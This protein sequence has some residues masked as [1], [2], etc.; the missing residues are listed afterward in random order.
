MILT[1][2]EG[3]IA[4]VNEQAEIL[5]GYGR[6]ELV[7]QKID[8]LLPERLRD[9]H[10]ADR[11]NYVAHP[12]MRLMGASRDVFA[13]RKDGAE[14]PV[15]IGLSPIVTTAGNMVLSA[16]ADITAR[17][18][19]EESQQLVIREL[20]HRTQNLLTVVQTVANRS[21]DEAKTIADAKLV[22]NGRL[23]AL[24]HAYAMLADA[25]WEG[26]PL[27]KIIERQ[28]R[29]MS[30]RI[31]VSGCDLIVVPSAA[32]QFAMIIHELTTNALKYGSLSTPQ[33][34]VSIEGNIDRNGTN[35]TLSFVWREIGGPTIAPPTR[36]G[37]GSVI[38]LDSAKSFAEDV[39]VE[40]AP[41]GLVYGLKLRLRDIEANRRA[42]AF[43]AT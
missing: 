13:R 7:G 41:T 8:M 18:K 21:M 22:M 17:K 28:I 11:A 39:S 2:Q 37:F 38:L 34:S 40:Y 16:I 12:I 4:L 19:A 31:K 27:Q 23:K 15:E 20:H 25:S 5:F 35:G 43:R 29:G 30:G 32:Q 14:V 6:A 36:R 3:R 1:D 9:K 33:G 10:P 24:S 42:D 26:A